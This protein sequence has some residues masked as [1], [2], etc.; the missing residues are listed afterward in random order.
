M[1]GY[2]CRFQIIF[3]SEWFLCITLA[4][5]WIPGD[6]R[7]APWSSRLCL[8]FGSG[9]MRE[10]AGNAEKAEVWQG[11]CA[12]VGNL[13]EYL[14]KMLSGWVWRA[15]PVPGSWTPQTL[16]KPSKLPGFLNFLC[17]ISRGDTA[18]FKHNVLWVMSVNLALLW[19][20]KFK[21]ATKFHFHWARNLQIL[22]SQDAWG[23]LSLVLL[24]L[25]PRFGISRRIFPDWCQLRRLDLNQDQG[26]GGIWDFGMLKGRSLFFAPPNWGFDV[27]YLE[28]RVTRGSL[29]DNDPEAEP[30]QNG[31]IRAGLILEKGSW[32]IRRAQDGKVRDE[33][34]WEK[35]PG[36]A[37]ELRREKSGLVFPWKR[38]PEKSGELRSEKPGMVYPGK[39][40]LKSQ[41]CSEGKDQGW[42]PLTKDPGW[43]AELRGEGPG[44]DLFGK[45]ILE[46]QESWEGISQSC[47][48]LE[49]GSWMSRRTQNGKAKAGFSLEKGSWK[50]RIAQKGKARAGF[51]W[52]RD[53]GKLRRAQKGRASHH[54]L[55][56]PFCLTPNF[57]FSTVKFGWK[58]IKQH[59]FQ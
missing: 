7:R 59:N 28:L 24:L 32:K 16:F 11:E 4:V 36:W 53:P 50:T 57:I 31:R 14:T 42:V 43:A 5:S 49:K 35:G 17:V 9:G 2:K 51:P 48:F 33:F 41:E 20:R 38:D 40:I 22:R 25:C 26:D 13:E 44:M 12:R 45:V 6:S 19:P 21:Y 46:E 55:L 23:I 18:H 1:N 39:G 10:E 56:F 29:W 3:I 30:A 54:V 47:F 34:P 37:G 8:V 27:D 52:K 58:G 15:L